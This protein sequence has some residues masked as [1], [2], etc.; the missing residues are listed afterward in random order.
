[1][2]CEAVLIRQLRQFFRF[3]LRASTLGA[4]VG[5][6][7]GGSGYLFLWSLTKVTAYRVDH[8]DL[9]YLL[10]LAGFVIGAAY[11]YL[12]GRS[13]RG[14]TLLLEEIHEPTSWLPRRM[15]PLILAGTLWT[16]LFGGSVGRE[17]TALQMSG[18]L[19]DTAM[20]VLRIS[21]AER[22]VMLIASLAGGF[23]AVFGVPIAGTVFALEVQSIG[24]LRFRA[25]L[26]AGVAAFVGD[27]LVRRLGFEH[28]T[29]LDLHP[30]VDAAL[31]GK[32]AIAGVLFGVTAAAFVWLTE[33]LKARTTKAL[34]WRPWRATIGGLIVVPLILVAGRE[35]SGLSLTLSRVALEGHHVAS[36]AF[37]V[38]LLATALCLGFGFVGGEVTPLFVMG[39]ALGITLATPLGLP[40]RL[41]A[42][43]GFVSVFG[44]AAKTP[45]ACA[46]MAVELFGFGIAAPALVS[47]GCAAAVLVLFGRGL[48]D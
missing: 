47:C 14:H 10:P 13:A 3:V 39:A 8:P 35:Y 46:V 9:L 22:R 31:L 48:Y 26:P 41:A 36:Y 29:F 34:P 33:E 19:T 15:A 18:S 5:A 27:F 25:L 12:G 42:S 43:M 7:A 1:M 40:A 37:A 24:R 30:R 23:G 45:L 21:G 2:G 20:R 44:G 16:H 11:H 4:L 28:E 38:K 17:G 32:F 6:L